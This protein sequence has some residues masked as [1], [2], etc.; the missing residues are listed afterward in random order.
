[1]RYFISLLAGIAIVHVA[2]FAAS[3]DFTT[4]PENTWLKQSPREGVAT[5]KF[6]YE[7]SGAFDPG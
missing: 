5:P 4:Y 6:Y 2:A 1:M 3:F 7:G